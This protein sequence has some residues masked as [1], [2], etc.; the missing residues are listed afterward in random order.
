MLAQN[1]HKFRTRTK[2]FRLSRTIRWT[3]CCAYAAAPGRCGWPSR[4][5]RESDDVAARWL[6]QSAALAQPRRRVRLFARRRIGAHRRRQR[7][8]ITRGR[9]RHVSEGHRN[10]H[11]LVNKSPRW[12]PIWRWALG[13]RTTWLLAPISTY[14][15]QPMPATSLTLIAPA[16]CSPGQVFPRALE[17]GLRLPSMA[18]TRSW[19]GGWGL[20]KLLRAEQRRTS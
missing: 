2:G 16:M 13:I 7:D 20:P 3:L 12:P 15:T 19:A 1:R 11:H 5:R 14:S 4:F 6:V 18:L 10:G 8:R 9:F 17:W